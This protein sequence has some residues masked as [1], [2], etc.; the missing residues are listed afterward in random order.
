VYETTHNLST[1]DIMKFQVKFETAVLKGHVVAGGAGLPSKI[2]FIAGFR[3]E[4]AATFRGNRPAPGSE[5]LCEL[6]RDTLP[7]NPNRGALLVRPLEKAT[8]RW[9][10][11]VYGAP[12]FGVSQYIVKA[13][14]GFREL[15]S[16]EINKDQKVAQQEKA[17]IANRPYLAA[18]ER[19]KALLPSL[20]PTDD[21]PIGF[22]TE[23]EGH[24][25][26]VRVFVQGVEGDVYPHRFVGYFADSTDMT[27][28][29][30]VDLGVATTAMERYIN[31]WKITQLRQV[32]SDLGVPTIRPNWQ[33]SHDVSW[34]GGILAT[35]TD[36][37]IVEAEIPTILI[38]LHAEENFLRAVVD[39]G[40][41]F[42]TKL[43][44][45]CLEHVS[46][47]SREG[48]TQLTLARIMSCPPEIRATVTARLQEGI[49][50]RTEHVA[51]ARKYAV[52]SI[53]TSV[54]SKKLQELSA[55]TTAEHATVRIHRSSWTSEYTSPD[56]RGTRSDTYY[57]NTVEVVCNNGKFQPRSTSGYGNDPEVFGWEEEVRLLILST[58][59]QIEAEMAKLSEL[60]ATMPWLNGTQDDELYA[61]VDSH[62]ETEL[63]LRVDAEYR[64]VREA[65]EFQVTQAVQAAKVRAEE[66]DAERVAARKIEAEVAIRTEAAA[67]HMQVKNIIGHP[68]FGM[69]EYDLRE[70]LRRATKVSVQELP[71]VSVHWSNN[72][73]VAG[74]VTETQALVARFVVEYEEK[75]RKLEELLAAGE[76]LLNFGGKHRWGGSTNQSRQWVIQPDGQERAPDS[77]PRERNGDGSNVWKIVESGEL[78]ISWSKIDTGSDHE[79]FVHKLPVG[80]CTTQQLLTVERLE[81]EIAQR[82]D[83]SVGMSGRTSPTVG[84]GWNLGPKMNRFVH[85]VQ[86]ETSV[87]EVKVSTP[88]VV[89]THN[90]GFVFKCA[91]HYVC[92]Q[93]QKM[94][95]LGNIEWNVFNNTGSTPLVCEHCHASGYVVKGDSSKSTKTESSAHTKS[96]NTPS[97]T[98]LDEFRARFG[99]K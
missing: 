13:F 64:A 39:C 63:S 10:E 58:V 42:Q 19:V 67:L 82:F 14:L 34:P 55:L 2:I 40:G 80:G 30:S 88:A 98:S 15:S 21:A 76:I 48:V 69:V 57:T 66:L 38:D 94:T 56:E 8:V 33:G 83:G 79:F 4:T 78:A 59:E 35:L 5:W 43:T 3:P 16:Y 6:V 17:E 93:C 68:C 81:N 73:T 49:R 91:R 54:L 60:C 32:M 31:S 65:L 90:V 45:A 62:A 46:R 24:P 51:E 70:S 99:R 53:E 87:S 52:T 47:Y 37:V 71:L 95:K 84:N 61:C 26:Q 1:E 96:T 97:T 92:D 77:S 72:L 23:L 25:G 22:M 29:V 28:V 36:N 44:V 75:F 18:V 20:V 74:Y 7:D 85:E 11:V 86:I 41:I 9:K 12:L 27:P 89:P 50:P